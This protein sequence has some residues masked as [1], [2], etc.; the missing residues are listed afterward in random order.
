MNLPPPPPGLPADV[1][2]YLQRLVGELQRVL[3]V[4]TQTGLAAH[5]AYSLPPAGGQPKLIIVVNDERGACV[6]WNPAGDAWLRL[7]DNTPIIPGPAFDPPVVRLGEDDVPRL[8]EA[9]AERVTEGSVVLTGSD[10]LTEDGQPR[11]TMT[12]RQRLTE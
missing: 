8:D 10:R 9:G 5:S 2:G 3:T 12:G 6:A 11:L 1:G 4:Q 7:V